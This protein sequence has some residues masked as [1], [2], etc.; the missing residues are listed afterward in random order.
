MIS[1]RSIL[2]IAIVLNDNIHHKQV[3]GAIEYHANTFGAK[4]MAKLIRIIPE[5]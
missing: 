2:L 5:S 4:S 3:Q 1:Y